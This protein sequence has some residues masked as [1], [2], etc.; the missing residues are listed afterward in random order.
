MKVAII[1]VLNERIVNHNDIDDIAGELFEGED[2]IIRLDM[3]IGNSRESLWKMESNQT[4]QKEP[5][6]T[7]F[8]VEDTV[9]QG[10]L[11]HQ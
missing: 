1:T 2:Y 8:T 5:A 9:T 3:Q 11:M 4:N 6:A 10:E 7:T